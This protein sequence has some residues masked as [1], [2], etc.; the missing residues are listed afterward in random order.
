MAAAAAC[1]GSEGEERRGAEERGGG[2]GGR[3][4]EAA[5]GG[6]CGGSMEGGE[7]AAG[8]HWGRSP[9][10]AHNTDVTHSGG[11]GKPRPSNRTTRRDTCQSLPGSGGADVVVIVPH[12][13]VVRLA[14]KH[15]S[16]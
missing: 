15:R 11:G 12:V 3:P 10:D 5:A 4:D 13:V 7:E 1:L 6:G 8:P 16:Q 9:D 2:G 14:E